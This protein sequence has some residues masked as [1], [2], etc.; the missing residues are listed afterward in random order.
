MASSEAVAKACNLTTRRVQQLVKLGMP[1]TAK[2]EYELGPC[3][4]WYIK[5]LQQELDRRGPSASAASAGIIA[6]REGLTAAQRKR[7]EMENAVRTGELADVEDVRKEWT[8]LVANAQKRL[9]AIPASIGPQLTNL[10]DPA[11]IVR[12]LKNEIDATL[13]E[14]AGVATDR[15]P[16]SAGRKGVGAAA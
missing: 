1:K 16:Q 2:G 13:K 4:A 6:E 5:F 15:K 3:M 7:V 8:I 11:A 12:R 14:L 10:S 9:R